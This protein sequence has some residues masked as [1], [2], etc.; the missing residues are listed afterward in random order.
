MYLCA[1]VICKLFLQDC[2]AAHLQ[3][4]VGGALSG[5]LLQVA[6]P[7]FQTFIESVTPEE[8][9]GE[10]AY[11]DGVRYSN[12]QQGEDIQEPGVVRILY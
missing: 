10:G 1:H 7:T 2:D 6:R 9:T 4:N 5:M 3:R 12:L 11:I 8:Y